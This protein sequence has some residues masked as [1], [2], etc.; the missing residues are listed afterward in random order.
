MDPNQTIRTTP[1]GVDNERSSVHDRSSPPDRT[2]VPERTS[3][4]D[5]TG[6][7]VWNHP[8][9]RQA[10]DDLIRP[11][12]SRPISPTPPAQTREEVTELRGM[13]SSV[14]DEAYNQKAAYRAI[15]NRLDQAEREFVEHRANARERNQPPPD[16]LRETL[17]PQNA[18]AFGT[19][20]IPRARS[21]R[22]TRD[23]SQ[24]P[25]QQIM[26]QRSLSYSGLD[27]IDTRLQ[28]QRS[29]PIQSQNIYMERT[30]EPRN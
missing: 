27:E 16:P 7:R 8:G 21:G 9:E 11:Q 1:S 22:Y 6:A 30:G 20:E 3:I 18:G 14:I 15:A 29:T 17:N 19:P 28:A 10:T 26:P 4:P 2:S 25:P 5:R 13:V 23:N 24:R 12:S